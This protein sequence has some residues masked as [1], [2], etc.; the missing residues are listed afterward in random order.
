MYVQTRPES[1][2]SLSVSAFIHL[3][4]LSSTYYVC[5]MPLMSQLF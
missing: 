2:L 5:E 4:G 3:A 1:S